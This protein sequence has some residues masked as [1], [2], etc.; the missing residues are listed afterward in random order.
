MPS[1]PSKKP[2]SPLRL[3]QM[4][5]RQSRVSLDHFRSLQLH[6][7]TF[8]G[9]CRFFQGYLRSLLGHLRFNPSQIH[10]R[11][12]QVHSRSSQV[13]SRAFKGLFSPSQMPFKTSWSL[14]GYFSCL[15]DHL[16]CLPVDPK[17][18]PGLSS[19]LSQMPP[20]LSQ[21]PP[22]PSQML[23][24]SSNVPP[25]LPQ[26]TAYASQVPLG[27]LIRLQGHTIFLPYHL[28]MPPRPSQLYALLNQT[29]AEI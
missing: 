18:F 19:S 13:H 27:N 8:L 10:S 22:I 7:G 28:K 15:S 3:S 17:C 6:I 23:L 12:Y 2:L 4:Y 21:V 26:G 29:T 25:P 9:H 24:G 16:R 5:F 20:R 14:A 11:P 1:C